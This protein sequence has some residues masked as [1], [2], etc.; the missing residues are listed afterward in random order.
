M[1]VMNIAHCSTFI[2]DGAHLNKQYG[3]FKNDGEDLPTCTSYFPA[4]II[5]SYITNLGTQFF[6]GDKK[7]SDGETVDT[8]KWLTQA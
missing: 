4:R 8:L 6:M 3:S 7:L 1:F 5:R 2:L